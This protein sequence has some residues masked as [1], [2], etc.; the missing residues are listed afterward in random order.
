MTQRGTGSDSPRR[1]GKMP[2]CHLSSDRQVAG[3]GRRETAGSRQVLQAGIDGRSGPEALWA[4]H[5]LPVPPPRQAAAL[6]SCSKEPCASRVGSQPLCPHRSPTLVP[7]PRERLVC[8][9]GEGLQSSRICSA[10]GTPCRS[11]PAC[12]QPLLPGQGGL[13]AL[14]WELPRQSCLSGHSEAASSNLQLQGESEGDF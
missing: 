10:L 14:R 6:W 8:L 1:G 13:A 5:G 3:G 11:L 2:F 9:P 12:L 7:H 4:G